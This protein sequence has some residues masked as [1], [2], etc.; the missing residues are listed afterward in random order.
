MQWASY[1]NG[2]IRAEYN[3]Q[4]TSFIDEIIGAIAKDEMVN[5][6]GT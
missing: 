3:I 6:S 4:N 1:D 2:R 5:F